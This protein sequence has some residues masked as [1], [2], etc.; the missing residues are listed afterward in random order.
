MNRRLT[1]LLCLSL[2]VSTLVLAMPQKATT[3]QIIVTVYPDESAMLE[4]LGHVLKN[5]GIAVAAIAGNHKQHH[6][7]NVQPSTV[8]HLLDS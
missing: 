1:V 2:S 6:H 5:N 7:E 3:E 4:A 8:G